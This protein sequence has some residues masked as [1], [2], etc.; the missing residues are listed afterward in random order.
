ML[1]ARL[2]LRT[3]RGGETKGWRARRLS[4]E[5]Q[6]LAL[7]VVLEDDTEQ[8]VGADSGSTLL[9]ALE[10]SDFSD[11]WEGGACGWPCNCSTCRVYID[12]PWAGQFPSR[13]DDET[14]MLEQAADQED[15]EEE[16][17]DYM[18]PRSRLSCQLRLG[19]EHQGLVVRLPELLI[20]M[21]EI[22]LWMRKR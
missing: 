2:V 6:R 9:E 16:A 3:V 15:D 11:V 17:E 7:T 8:H 18:A 5:P 10:R 1:A 22:P 21:M 14:E 20:N 19:P 13:D 12:E 4:F